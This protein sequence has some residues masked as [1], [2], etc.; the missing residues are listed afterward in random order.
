M[1]EQADISL[2]IPAFNE[3]DCVEGTIREAVDAL[4]KLG[5]KFEVIA[6][7]DGSSDRTPEILRRL[8]ATTPELRVLSLSPRSGQSAAFGAGF[9]AAGG[10]HIVLMDADGQ[11]DPAD[12]P[13]L[14]EVLKSC[15]VCCG[16]RRNRKDTFARNL[17]SKL[18]NAIRNLILRDGII[19]TGCSL[20]AFKAEFVR[21]LP[22]FLKGMHRFLP[23][24]AAMRG[25]TIKQIPVNHRPRKGGE[26][27]YTNVGR[28]M[29]TI[30]DLKAVRWMQRR[31]CRFRAEEN[32]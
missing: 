25:A 14:L 27:K 26:S 20:K 11:N 29:V 32:F 5:R 31:A 3:E 13:A 6:V 16:W 22:M 8:R 28:L 1:N 17:G 24:L 21:D 19:D 7:N 9:K 23:A 4:R 30:A 2:I 12:I 10:S 18:A 15:D